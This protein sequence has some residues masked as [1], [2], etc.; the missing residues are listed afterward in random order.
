MRVFQ[1]QETIRLWHKHSWSGQE[2]SES[3]VTRRKGVRDSRKGSWNMAG[4]PWTGSEQWKGGYSKDHFEL[5]TKNEHR[6]AGGEQKWGWVGGGLGRGDKLGG[7]LEIQ[8]YDFWLWTLE[9]SWYFTWRGE[10]KE[11]QYHCRKMNVLSLWSIPIL[12]H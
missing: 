4:Q 12:F 8:G 2:K 5:W 11:F 6:R 9:P 1:E 10:E 7:C 3:N